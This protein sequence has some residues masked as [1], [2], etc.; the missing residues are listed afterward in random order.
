MQDITKLLALLRRGVD[1]DVAALLV[2]VQLDEVLVD[3]Q[4]A[5]AV[6]RAVAEFEAANVQR[7][8]AAAADDWHAAAWLIERAFPARWARRASRPVDG[9]APA[10]D[11]DQLAERRAARRA[12]E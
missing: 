7:V 5:A 11:L 12:A 4:W 8:V 3:P 9:P 10:D 1:R 2:D 6:E